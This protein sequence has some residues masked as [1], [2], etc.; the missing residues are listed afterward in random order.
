M[1]DENEEAEQTKLVLSEWKT[2]IAT[3]MHFNEL[4]IRARTTGV[5]VVM[6]VYGAAA[7]AIGQYPRQYL[8]LRGFKVHVAAAIIVFGLL[9]LASIFVLDFFYYYRML[10]GAVRR[11]EE[12]DD[13]YS[14]RVVDGSKLF[15]MTRLISKEVS[16]CRAILCLIG[17]YLCPSVAGVASL[18]YLLL[19][20][21]P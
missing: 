18:L 15:G 6:G 10:I 2:V 8:D 14:D 20:Y 9:L 17:F 21:S 7:L 1:C 13:A 11:G 12:I 16:R 19:W 4:I 3:Q 5:S